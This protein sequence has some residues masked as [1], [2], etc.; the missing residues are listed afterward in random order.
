MDFNLII[1]SEFRR[2]CPSISEKEYK[3]IELEMLDDFNYPTI[4]VWNNIILYD[5]YRYEISMKNNTKIYIKEMSFVSRYDALLYA[6]KQIYFNMTIPSNYHRYLIG[7]GLLCIKKILID[8]N[9]GIRE[10]PFDISD[11]SP[12][13][14]KKGNGRSAFITEKEFKVK[15]GTARWYSSYADALEIINENN[16]TI[17][18]ELMSGSFALS[19]GSTITL[20]KATKEQMLY[21]YSVAKKEAT[22]Y[23]QRKSNSSDA[24]TEQQDKASN[25]IL[26]RNN[27]AT[28]AIKQTPKFDPDAEISSLTLTIPTWISLMNRA[29]KHSD[30]NAVSIKARVNLLTKLNELKKSIDIIQLKLEGENTNE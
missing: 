27:A 21:I 13:S 10:L 28:P 17:F 12:E 22:Y 20:S 14:Y 11:F 24:K 9:K 3:K 1:D 15:A 5:F 4:E 25:I 29:I 7:K 2:L 16:P 23:K 30:M 26:K 18:E 19:V 6:C 8:A